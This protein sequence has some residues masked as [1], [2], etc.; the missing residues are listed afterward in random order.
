MSLMESP[1]RSPWF[2][3][4]TTSGI[5]NSDFCGQVLGVREPDE[6]ALASSDYITWIE[7]RYGGANR[8]LH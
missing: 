5:G 1:V 8:Q 2:D 4:L 7:F 3:K 6:A